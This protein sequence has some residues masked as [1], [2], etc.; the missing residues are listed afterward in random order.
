MTFTDAVSRQVRRT[1][2]FGFAL[3]LGI[4]GS[5]VLGLRLAVPELDN[6][7]WYV[8][9]I[10]PVPLLAMS[11][12]DKPF[13]AW[14]MAQAVI[15]L[16]IDGYL[17][18]EVSPLVAIGV[19]GCCY[20]H[21]ACAAMAAL[22]RVDTEVDPRIWQGWLARVGGVSAVSAALAGVVAVVGDQPIEGPPALMAAAAACLV[23][24]VVSGV[25]WLY[26]RRPDQ[27]DT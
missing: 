22:W 2:S 9:V 18:A 17:S 24:A 27:T 1:L 6:W 10:V 7:I 5:G 3:R 23:L 8:L 19:G 21:H 13:P 20:L 16:L 4:L 26:H 25:A 11:R 15:M 14:T 12:P